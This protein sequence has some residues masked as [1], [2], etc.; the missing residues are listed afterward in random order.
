MSTLEGKLVCKQYEGR[1]RRRTVQR[2]YHQQ[3]AGRCHGWPAA[4]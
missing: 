3:T 4:S 1:N 2:I